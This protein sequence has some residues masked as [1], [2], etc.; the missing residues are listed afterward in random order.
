MGRTVSFKIKSSNYDHGYDSDSD[1]YSTQNELPFYTSSHN[2]VMKCKEDWYYENVKQEI[3]DLSESL[4]DLI[5]HKED[6]TEEEKEYK[7]NWWYYKEREDCSR[8]ED[9]NIIKIREKHAQKNETEQK[10]IIEAISVLF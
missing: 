6:V 5:N 4:Q 10:N 2:D 3:C 1:N 9:E 7:E 8:S